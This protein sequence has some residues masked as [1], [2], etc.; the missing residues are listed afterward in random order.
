METGCVAARKK[1]SFLSESIKTVAVLDKSSAQDESS[2]GFLADGPN[3]EWAKYCDDL[4]Q[5]RMEASDCVKLIQEAE[6]EKSR[7]RAMYY[8]ASAIAF[9]APAHVRP[10]LREHCLPCIFRLY[11]K[12]KVVAIR[13]DTKIDSGAALLRSLY[14]LAQSPFPELKNDSPE[15]VCSLREWHM[16][17]VPK[18]LPTLL[19]CFNYMFYPFVGGSRIMLPNGFGICL[20]IL[21]DNPEKHVPG[22][23]PRN[24]LAVPSSSASFATESFDLVEFATDYR[25]PLAQRIGHHR[26]CHEH[27]FGVEDRL[28]L[29]KWYISRLNRLLYELVDCANFTT[30]LKKENTIDPI[31]GYEHQIT[32]DRLLRKTL[33]SM[34][35][36]VANHANLM[37]F[38]IADLYDTLSVRL[39]NSSNDT[40]FFKSLFNTNEVPKRIRNLLGQLPAPFDSYFPDVA[41]KAYRKIEETVVASVW[42]KQKVSAAGI[43]VR[44]K[45]L[46]SETAVSPS[47]FTS[48]VMRAYR[49]AHHGYFSAGDRGNRPSRYLFLVDGNLPVEMSALPVLWWLT[50]LADPKFVGWEH[51]EISAYD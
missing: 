2:F 49:N 15:G 41:D 18:L 9:A 36:D 43:I 21:F 24:W 28:T 4:P 35:L 51:L 44:N 20:L 11:P 12:A 19:D 25:G 1:G 13:F 26:F 14:A 34:S 33:L 45:D 50:Y 48:E 38:E 30:D 6:N 3:S 40:G 10:L 8:L 29:F 27:G 16:L 32:V 31:F 17:S 42:R 46:T 22:K 47:E 7:S 37:R 5:F 39:G 23:Y